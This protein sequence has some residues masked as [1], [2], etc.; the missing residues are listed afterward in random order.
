MICSPSPIGKSVSFLILVLAITTLGGSPAMAQGVQPTDAF[1]PLEIRRENPDGSVA[2]TVFTPVNDPDTGLPEWVYPHDDEVPEPHPSQILTVFHPHTPVEGERFPA[3]MWSSA[4]SFL[5]SAPPTADPNANIFLHEA[6]SR[7]WAVVAVGTTGIGSCP[8]PSQFPRCSSGNPVCPADLDPPSCR[9]YSMW[10]EPDSE[11]SSPWNDFNY[12]IGE[13]DFLMARQFVAQRADDMSIDNDKVVLSGVSAGAHYSAFVAYRAEAW[14]QADFSSR[15]LSAQAQTDPSVAAIILFESV[16]WFAGWPGTGDGYHWPLSPGSFERAPLLENV[17][18]GGASPPGVLAAAGA[19]ILRSSSSSA[20]ARDRSPQVPT[21]LISGDGGSVLSNFRV[22]HSIDPHAYERDGD[23][24]SSP[25]D[26]DPKILLNPDLALHDYWFPLFLREDL[27][28]VAPR[29]HDH[30]S[31]LRFRD[32]PTDP[33]YNWSFVDPRF[34]STGLAPTSP[35]EIPLIYDTFGDVCGGICSPEGNQL[36]VY[37]AL[38]WAIREVCGDLAPS[39]ECRNGGANYNVL[40]STTPGIGGD[41][42][43]TVDMNEV[44]ERYDHALFVAV[45]EDPGS[46]GSA[47]VNLPLGN[48]DH[49][50]FLDTSGLGDLLDGTG[51]IEKD[52]TTG[53]ATLVTPIPASYSPGNVFVVVALVADRCPPGVTCDPASPSHE[54]LPYALTNA[55]DLI[56]TR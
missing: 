51:F 4:G 54:V 55:Q 34:S 17:G 43:L 20:W 50:L 36:A 5:T 3:I 15:T 1:P 19:E 8:T 11:E 7:G 26:R 28:L 9:D 23:S 48:G 21:M 10:F 18:G 32:A 33:T 37:P 49:L 53:L 16:S 39:V 25:S 14:D 41:V 30:H 44:D 22:D 35:D 47:R 40:R 13:K 6:L 38:D 42:T 29:Y 12:F 52:A 27:D 2:S 46:P 56:L 45:A 24:T 31:R